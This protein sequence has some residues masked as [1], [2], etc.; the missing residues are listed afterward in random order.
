M[1]FIDPRL[2]QKSVNGVIASTRVV[3]AKAQALIWDNKQKLANEKKRVE[4]FEATRDQ[5]QQEL[6]VQSSQ[7]EAFQAQ[8]TLKKLLSDEELRVQALAEAEEAWQRNI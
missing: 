5:V 4:E 3:I 1:T 2:S 8:L 6:N 7:V